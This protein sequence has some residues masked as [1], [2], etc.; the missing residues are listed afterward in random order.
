MDR[1]D[2]KRLK[3]L[4]KFEPKGPPPPGRGVRVF[5][6]CLPTASAVSRLWIYSTIPYDVDHLEDHAG[7]E[8]PGIRRR[9]I[10]DGTGPDIDWDPWQP[11]EIKDLR[12]DDWLVRVHERPDKPVRVLA[13]VR[14][15][16]FSHPTGSESLVWHATP[17][18]IHSWR[19]LKQM[20]GTVVDG[21]VQQP[22][23]HLVTKKHIVPLLDRFRQ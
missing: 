7:Q 2:E 3:Y 22:V 13:P 14:V 6:P 15:I 21:Y 16:G 5:T 20:S 12:E 1:L 18:D 19:S 11:D 10:R 8:R 4:E 23:M 17:K 9:S